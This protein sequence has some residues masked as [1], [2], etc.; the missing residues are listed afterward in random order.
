VGGFNNAF[1]YRIYGLA[2]ILLRCSK[3]YFIKVVS[4]KFCGDI[5]YKANLDYKV[6]LNRKVKFDYKV[7]IDHKIKPDHKAELDHKSKFD[8]K[9]KP[10]HIAEFDHK[11][12]LDHKI[13]L[14]HKAELDHKT[15][16]DHKPKLDYKSKFDNK[17]KLYPKAICFELHQTGSSTPANHQQLFLMMGVSPYLRGYGHLANFI[18]KSMTTEDT[19]ITKINKIN[20][21]KLIT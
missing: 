21:N 3:K 9:V 19:H 4:L 17:T 8:H 2:E 5:D 12:K 16:P 1:L 18:P 7:K 10:D 20:H 13:K 11:T 14:D 15:K 6:K